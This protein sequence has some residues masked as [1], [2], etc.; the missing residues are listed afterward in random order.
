MKER[1]SESDRIAGWAYREFNDYTIAKAGE[2]IDDAPVWLGAQ[3]KVPVA[4]A[5]EVTVTL[6]RSARRSMKVTAE[7]DHAVKAPIAKG[8]EVGKLMVTAAD[9][10][11]LEVPLV[12]TQAV[13][14]LDAFSRVGAAAGYLLWGKK[15]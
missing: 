7:Y 12:A 14:R 5:T 4:A 11:P 9:S 6:P 13:G 2:P 3:A 1:A 15:N 10:D 8:Q